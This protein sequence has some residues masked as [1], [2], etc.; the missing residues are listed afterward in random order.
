MFLLRLNRLRV[1]NIPKISQFYPS[2]FKS[3]YEK[4]FTFGAA[5]VGGKYCIHWL[6][7]FL[8]MLANVNWP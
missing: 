3:E 7:R 1:K 4:A 5:A 6:I 8:Q 2:P